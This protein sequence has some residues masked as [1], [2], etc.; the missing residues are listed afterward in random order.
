VTWLPVVTFGLGNRRTGVLGS[1]IA[2][3]HAFSVLGYRF[4]ARSCSL[5]C[6][7]LVFG[8]SECSTLCSRWGIWVMFIY[9]LFFIF[10][11]AIKLS[12]MVVLMMGA[13]WRFVSTLY[14]TRGM[15]TTTLSSSWGV[16][17][18]LPMN[19]IVL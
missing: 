18:L 2:G 17:V 10:Y 8:K 13:F 14:V 9:F 19:V 5:L 16:L 3:I 12:G 6:G 11:F 15:S 1:Y 4:W 7:M